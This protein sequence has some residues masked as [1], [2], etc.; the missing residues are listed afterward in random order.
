MS[1]RSALLPGSGKHRVRGLTVVTGGIMT[2]L[3][4]AP[5][6]VRA[7]AAEDP[8]AVLATMV[9]NYATAKA[10]TATII[11]RQKGKTKD[12]KQFSLTKT[13]LMKYKSPNL[14]NVVVTFVGDGA[15]AGKVAQGDQTVVADGKILTAYSPSRKVYVKKPDL[16][17]LTVLDLLDILKRIPTKTAENVKLLA[18]DTVNG[19]A[20]SVI[21]ISPMMPKTLTPEQQKQWKAAAAHANPL[22]LYVDKKDFALLRIAE[23]ANG[24]SVDVV[25]QNQLFNSSIPDNVFN[26]TPP[27]GSKEVTA[28]VA[29][30]VGGAPGGIPGGR[31]GVPALPP[32]K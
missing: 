18:P 1:V 26:Y 14:V 13:Q 23:T 15:A 21:Q 9:H 10:Y 3:A 22:R 17:T 24:G 12:G 32:H 31:P 2:Y 11:T 20:V 19:R 4:L 7:H 5:V 25:L 8:G 29:P 28:P 30:A 6:C 16:P 27:P